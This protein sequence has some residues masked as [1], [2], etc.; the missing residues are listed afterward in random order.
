L[1]LGAGTEA[2]SVIAGAA[3]A[4]AVAAATQGTGIET[5][6]S[7]AVADPGK[8][9][10]AVAAAGATPSVARPEHPE[11]A[12]PSLGPDLGLGK[13]TGNGA[14]KTG[15]SALTHARDRFLSP[16]I[17]GVGSTTTTATSAIAE[18]T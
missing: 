16:G 8:G 6:Q 4:V 7:Q 5:A 11:I 3:V 18:K 13:G 2:G 9:S 15:S 12:R 14:G 1:F 10:A 17:E